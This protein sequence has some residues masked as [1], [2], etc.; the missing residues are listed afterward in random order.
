VQVSCAWWRRIDQSPCPKTTE[1]DPLTR[2]RICEHTE[3]NLVLVCVA[4]SHASNV[5][6]FGS[7]G[8]EPPSEPSNVQHAGQ[9]T[10][11]KRAQYDLPRSA[12]LT[13][14]PFSPGNLTRFCL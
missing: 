8:S 10:D 4:G 3:R 11:S 5:G 6:G 13:L 9:E 14:T 2:S 7:R 1:F 12:K